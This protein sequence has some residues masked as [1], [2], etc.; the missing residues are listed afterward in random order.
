MSSW[1]AV[2]SWKEIARQKQPRFKGRSLCFHISESNFVPYLFSI[3]QNRIENWN[4]FLAFRISQLFSNTN[5]FCKILLFFPPFIFKLAFIRCRILR[6]AFKFYQP[7]V[8]FG[9][10]SIEFDPIAGNYSNLLYNLTIAI[11]SLEKKVPVDALQSRWNISR[12]LNVRS[13]AIDS[14]S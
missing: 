13:C 6:V 2:T 7:D 14:Q 3:L 10:T 4:W 11:R 5:L 9:V 8:W 1:I 12:R